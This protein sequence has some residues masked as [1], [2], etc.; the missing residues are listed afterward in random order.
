M[1][2]SMRVWPIRPRARRARVVALGAEHRDQVEGRRAAVTR[3]VVG[4]PAAAARVATSPPGY[5]L[6]HDSGDIARHCKLLSHLPAPGEVRAVVTPGRGRGE[7]HLDV[8]SRDRPGLLAAFTGVLAGSGL[9]V[10]QAVLATWADG[11]A[12]EAFVIRSA[13]PPDAGVLQDAF[14][15]SLDKPLSSPP[16][17]EAQVTFDDVV[18]ALY[19]RCDVRARDRPGL[20]HAVA[21]A[22]AS[23]GADVH[24]ARVTTVDGVARDRFDLSDSAGNKLDAT[25]KEAI[26]AG[27]RG[28][29]TRSRLG[30]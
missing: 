18:S 1:A 2:T 3:L 6:A 20:L 13:D 25:L 4:N 22:I 27:V 7:W 17:P 14:E 5:L 24:A 30:R 28:G 15:A 8:T 9:D 11:G 21:V 12:L 23:A 16:V 29:L 26:R 10:V 19:T